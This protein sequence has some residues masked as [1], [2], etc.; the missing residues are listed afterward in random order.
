MLLGILEQ[1]EDIVADDDTL[2]ALQNILDTHLD[3]CGVGL[4]SGMERGDDNEV[5]L[6]R[7]QLMGDVKLWSRA[8]VT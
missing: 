7:G 8:T 5:K 6:V 4:L 2:L 3:G 1:S